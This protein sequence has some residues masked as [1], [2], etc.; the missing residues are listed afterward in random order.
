M[1]AEWKTTQ[2]SRRVRKDQVDNAGWSTSAFDSPVIGHYCDNTRIIIPVP[3]E[4][5]FWAPIKHHGN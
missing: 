4:K 1:R 5:R 3:V 2:T